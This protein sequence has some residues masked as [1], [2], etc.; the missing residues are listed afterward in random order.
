MYRLTTSVPYLLNRVGVRMGLLFSRKI[1]PYGLNLPMYRVLASLAEQPNQ[2]LTD[3]AAMTSVEISTMSRMISTL[4]AKK[5]VTRTRLPSNERNVSI[6]LTEQ[7]REIAHH[8]MLEAAHYEEVASSRL[9]SADVEKL[10]R[11]LGE[12]YA[13]LDVLEGELVSPAVAEDDRPRWALPEP[14]ADTVA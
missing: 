13:S 1:E 12:I 11:I 6:S 8:L 7:G 10:K 4:V 5:L 2:K 9:D 3:L 14:V